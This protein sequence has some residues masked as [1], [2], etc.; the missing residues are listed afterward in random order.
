MPNENHDDE[1]VMIDVLQCLNL[2][3]H[4]IDSIQNDPEPEFDTE[5]EF[6]PWKAENRHQ[7]LT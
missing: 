5:S 1:K 6:E 4:F 2:V 7:N 3:T